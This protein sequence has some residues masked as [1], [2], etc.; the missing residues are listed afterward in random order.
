MLY[1]EPTNNP[2][3]FVNNGELDMFRLYVS[4]PPTRV[5][6]LRQ[7]C[8]ANL[9]VRTQVQGCRSARHLE[10]LGN[11]QT[12]R[13]VGSLYAQCQRVE[14]LRLLPHRAAHRLD[15]RVRSIGGVEKPLLDTLL[16]A[17]IKVL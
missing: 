11:D 13:H 4:G 2:S 12:I 15:G 10:R 5:H 9:I 6:A 14:C 16:L 17:D 3:L 1:D 7:T 8:A